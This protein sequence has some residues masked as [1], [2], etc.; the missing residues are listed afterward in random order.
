MKLNKLFYLLLALPLVFAA[1]E[2]T[3]EPKPS[4]E[5]SLE[6]TSEEVMMFDAEGGEGAILW[7]INEVTRYE[8]VPMPEPTFMTEA[9]WITLSTDT[10]GAFTVATNES[11]AREAVIRVEFLEQEFEITVKQA[12]K[13]VVPEPEFAMDVTM[14]GAYRAAS[15]EFGLSDNYFVLAFADDAENTELGII[16]VGAEEENILQ[17][18][19]YTSADDTLLAEE[20]QVIVWDPAAAYS[21][22]AGEATV[23]LEDE[24]Y[25]FDITLVDE[26][27]ARYHFAYE[28]Y[29]MEMV[30]AEKPEAEAFTPVKVE[31]YR[32]S[33]WD[34]GNFEL[35]LYIDESNYHS[36]DMMDYVNPNEGYLSAGNYSMED[37]SVTSWSNFLYD[38]ETGEGAFV[39]A[40][41]IT[42]THNEDGTTTIE[43][44]FESEYGNHLD[45]NWT[46]VVEGFDFSVAGGGNHISTLTEDLNLDGMNGGYSLYYY[47][48]WYSWDTDNWSFTICEDM[49]NYTG[50][51][52]M[53][54]LLS[55]P[56]ADD[57][58]GEY[59]AGNDGSY[60]LYTFVKGSLNGSF[61]SGTWYGEYTDGTPTGDS[62]P[63]VGGTITI[64]FNED[65][66][67]SVTLDCVD[68]AGN[69]ITGTILAKK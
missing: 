6:I 53:L 14:A 43:G 50:K 30:P 10:L 55:S 62:A 25:T 63:I 45:I 54:D 15:V 20:C 56:S 9:E 26:E 23:T 2:P 29:V 47:G 36:L 12:A 13:V 5:Y 1:C 7:S 33:S 28:G 60:E 48:D 41:E 24:Y 27:D 8:P 35:D 49:E 3:D 19:T 18:G 58:R 59:K 16:L 61:R 42:I 21:F 52:L 51:C 11:E 4:K 68:D 65:G 44:Y 69:K 39:T 66:S 64:V 46:G 40:A 17:A 57:C 37:G 38:I 67:K 22:V 32:T 34:L 31:A